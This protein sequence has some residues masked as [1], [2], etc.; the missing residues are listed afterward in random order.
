MSRG[1]RQAALDAVYEEIQQ[2]L[3]R[4]AGSPSVVYLDT[5]TYRLVEGHFKQLTNAGN[6]RIYDLKLDTAWGTV[7]I[8]R[9]PKVRIVRPSRSRSSTCRTSPARQCA[10]ASLGCRGGRRTT[11]SGAR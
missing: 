7:E 5:P 8:R 3:K 1:N 11:A 4:F 10:R 9:A 2:G 6:K